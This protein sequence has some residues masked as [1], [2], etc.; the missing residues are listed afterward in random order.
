M[1]S[2]SR[3]LPVQDPAQICAL[4]GAWNI[5]PRT[6][7]IWGFSLTANA[8]CVAQCHQSL[9]AAERA[10]AQRFVHARLR[11]DFVVAHGVLRHLLARCAQTEPSALRFSVSP[12]GKPLLAAAEKGAAPLSFNLTHAHGR[13]LLAIS[14]G[15]D[16]GID[17]EKIRDEVR[18]LV[19]ARRYFAESECAGVEAA[20]AHLRNQ[21]FFRYW[22]AKEAVLKAAGI[23]LHFPIDQFGVQFDAAGSAARIR[24]GKGSRLTADWTVQSLPVDEG[25]AAAVAARKTGWTVRIEESSPA[26]LATG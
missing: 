5:A 10:R 3:T 15:R 1:K 13:A 22:V 12:E 25:W 16:V 26:A 9:S 23:G 4:T 17:L 21:V 14:D 19:I 7:H 8:A 18:A 24:T 6:V 20:P 2:V 11:D